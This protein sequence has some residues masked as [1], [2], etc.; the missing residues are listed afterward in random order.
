MDQ[1]IYSM[2]SSLSAISENNLEKEK[3]SWWLKQLRN[4][5]WVFN[6]SQKEVTH[7]YNITGPSFFVDMCVCMCTFSW[8]KSVSPARGEGCTFHQEEL[9]SSGRPLLRIP[10]VETHHKY[11]QVFPLALMEDNSPHVINARVIVR[12]LFFCFKTINMVHYKNNPY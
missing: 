1:C 8:S 7:F 4:C 6:S 3:G 11:R 2:R 10:S 5:L 9:L 12:F